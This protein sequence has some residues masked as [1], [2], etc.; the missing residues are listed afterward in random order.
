MN[1]RLKVLIAE[2]TE[3]WQEALSILLKKIDDNLLIEIASTAEEVEK[4]INTRAYELIIFDLGLSLDST[5]LG[6]GEDQT[7]HNLL[8]KIRAN[9]NNRLCGIIVLIGFQQISNAI[10]LMRDYRAYSFFEKN[11][12]HS[13]Q[14]LIDVRSAILESRFSQIEEKL[15]NRH[16]LTVHF[17]S[18]SIVGS[19][20][21]GPNTAASYILDRPRM[22][23]C[24]EFARR[25]DNLN[26]IF[27]TGKGIELWRPEAKSIGRDIYEKLV[28]ERYFME[29]FHKAQS[30]VKST[31]DLWIHFNGSAN[32]LG[33][34]F[35]LI[36]N[37]LEYLSHQYIFTRSLTG[38]DVLDKKP[39]HT[40]IK[41][42]KQSNETLKILLVASNHDGSI[43]QAENEIQIIKN[44]ITSSVNQIGI[45]LKVDCLYTKE[46][47]TYENVFE[48]LKTGQYHIFHYSGHD[49]FVNNLPENSG[50]FL[51][52]Q[53]GIPKKLNAA[54]LN[55]LTQNSNLK[56]VYLSC[57]LSTKTEGRVGRGDFHGIFE[58]LVRAQ[59]PTI[60]GYRWTILDKSALQLAKVF[61]RELWRTLSP[62]EALYYAKQ[63]L[64]FDR[65]LDDET[66]TSPVLLMQNP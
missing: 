29:N 60:L 55:L 43:P 19:E 10:R 9:P 38:Y 14:F 41:D 53:S 64:I 5:S 22:F 33:V 34:P 59:I 15:N 52:D 57:C 24:S 31:T 21:D 61:Y 23:D 51:L 66:W 36:H 3:E 11:E 2:G 50:I 63:E 65:G 54:H 6:K 7:Y 39:F 45:N 16:Q 1:S 25:A 12:F 49:D 28:E 32:V 44:E 56:F 26:I 58:A 20:I 18:D 48:T 30:A 13:N 46:D 37:N 47:I 27:T 42:L 35:E 62:G 4:Y 8:S 40:F 17:N